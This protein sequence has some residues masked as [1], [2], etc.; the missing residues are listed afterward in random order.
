[1]KKYSQTANHKIASTK[2]TPKFHWLKMGKV[3]YFALHKQMLRNVEAFCFHYIP[4]HSGWSKTV[5]FSLRD[6]DGKFIGVF[7]FS[8]LHTNSTV[9]TYLKFRIRH[10]FTS[11]FNYFL[12]FIW[13]ST[14]ILHSC[15]FHISFYL[16]V[17]IF[18]MKGLFFRIS[19]IKKYDS[20]HI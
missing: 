16:V 10:F 1:M 2:I 14:W 11:I 9:L 17:I 18:S 3:I 7:F 20:N 6:S 13:F 5:S 19:T 4:L 12:R 8:F 15:R